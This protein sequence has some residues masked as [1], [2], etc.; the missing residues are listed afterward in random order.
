MASFSGTTPTDV[1]E[2]QKLLASDAASDDYFGTS[3]AISSDGSTAVVGAE[4]E[5]TSPNTD[6]GAAY[7]FTRVSGT[8]T[9]QQK[10]LASD[11]ASSDYFG[12]S[13]AISSDGNIILVGARAEDTSPA[14]D[15]GAAYVFTRSGATWTQQTKL[16]ASDRVTNDRFGY[17]V[18][19]SA[20]GLTA[21]VGAL[22]ETTA[23][24]SENGAAYVFT[25]TS[26]TWTQQAKLLA[27]DR[28]DF[29]GFGWA[30]SLSS[31]GDIAIIGSIYETTSPNT[32][33][34]AAYIFTRS[35]STWTQQQKLLASDASSDDNF[36]FSVDISEDGYTALIGAYNESTSPN[37]GNGAAYVFTRVSTTW[38]QQAKLL[39]LDAA[40]SDLFGTS[41]SLSGDG[42]TAL[43]GASQE[44]TFPNTINGAAYV[45]TRSGSTWTQQ[46]KILPSDPETDDYFSKAVAISSDASTAIIGSYFK[47]KSPNS[48]DG[49]AYIYALGRPLDNKLYSYDPT[50]G[51]WDISKFEELNS[52]TK[53]VYTASGTFT[54]PIGAKVIKV[55]CIGAGGGGGG[56]AR[57]STISTYSGGSGGGGGGLSD[58]IFRAEDLGG[59]G[60]SVTV[61]V[62]TGGTGGAVTATG[63]TALAGNAGVA[64]GTTSISSGASTFLRATGGGL[65]AGG[66]TTGT[67]ATGASGFGMFGGNGVGYDSGLPGG[68]Q[69]GQGSSS[70]AGASGGIPVSS[71]L[72]AATGS[73]S[74]NGGAGP[75]NAYYNGAGGGGAGGASSTTNGFTG[76]AGGSYGGGGGGGGEG[77]TAGA[78]GRGG[79][80]GVG[81]VGLV[82]FTVWYG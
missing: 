82:T 48:G 37:T 54:V 42:N 23:P 25:N 5:N 71:T 76:G 55:T 3:V 17:S 79:A 57:N 73:V 74:A 45:F 66:V 65:G 58:Y 15:Q 18:A 81:G 35:G 49:A 70:G 44:N 60:A 62:G 9:E 14:T 16:L 10:L 20:D 68:G 51:V 1:I 26:G 24:N 77:S 21:I 39:A 53:I 40:V 6:Q 63:T 34:G 52:P 19:L 33:N 38:T 80:G 36:G 28:G 47:S 30:V 27:S 11:A 50:L 78:S 59:A 29:D 43:I 72:T 31:N 69:G 22:F 61:T 13:V 4:I 12:T 64:G 67:N 7:I 2:L 32:I 46:Q 75:S 56:G 8:W 41:V